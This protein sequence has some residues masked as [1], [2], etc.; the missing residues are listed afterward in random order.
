ME[1]KDWITNSPD[2]IS[3]EKI[4]SRET[5][6]CDIFNDNNDFFGINPYHRIKS[7]IESNDK[8]SLEKS[9]VTFIKKM[10]NQ[11][12][13]VS[14]DL[15]MNLELL[16]DLFDILFDTPDFLS[17]I[18]DIDNRIMIL[19]C[20]FLIHSTLSDS[21]FSIFLFQKCY[22]Q[23]LMMN[24]HW[25]SL[26]C[27]LLH[28]VLSLNI[29]IDISV[30]HHEDIYRMGYV[31]FLIN[32]A[33]NVDVKTREPINSEIQKA[34]CSCLSVFFF[35][36]RM[37]SVDFVNNILEIAA[38]LCFNTPYC[39]RNH[40]YDLITILMSKRSSSC[41]FMFSDPPLI[42]LLLQDILTELPDLL[43]SSSRLMR[44]CL[45][46]ENLSDDAKNELFS[47]IEWTKMSHHLANST[48]VCE[49]SSL[50]I[51]LLIH[52]PSLSILF[53]E[54]GILGCIASTFDDMSILIR[55]LI[56]RV[57]YICGK[58]I[59][60]G[61]HMVEFIRINPFYVFSSM[62]LSE[63]PYYVT[64]ALE[65]TID[66][67]TK[68]YENCLNID[69]YIRQIDIPPELYEQ[70]ELANKLGLLIKC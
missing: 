52:D 40:L 7:I 10:N 68:C 23:R 26:E 67:I 28:L 49:I 33:G 29:F 15:I 43:V 48:I 37:L 42:D 24:L 44:M 9:L 21:R 1:Y 63:I 69:D 57:F 58:T 27:I 14:Y 4:H 16:H 6:F 11:E 60:Y 64:K 47:R 22:F 31:Q 61:D 36:A 38:S 66:L 19:I 13:T 54:N 56:F 20:R 30:E 18:S 50:L 25:M 59:T 45:K 62:I 2:N 55:N 35:H 65:I 46:N 41:E 32:I 53:I 39:C 5:F 17:F 3:F 12:C 70:Y 51:D 8:E 34:A